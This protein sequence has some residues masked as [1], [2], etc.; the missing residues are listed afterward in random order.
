MIRSVERYP[1]ETIVIVHAKIRKS[2]KRV[3]NA[4]IHTHEFE[5]YEIHKVAD[6]AENV[7]FSV[8]DAENINRDKEEVDEEGDEAEEESTLSPR[9][10]EDISRRSQDLLSRSECAGRSTPFPQLII[11]QVA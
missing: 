6:L 2:P 7:P 10:S 4:T 11:Q 1:S 9:A 3:K 8:Y 5:V